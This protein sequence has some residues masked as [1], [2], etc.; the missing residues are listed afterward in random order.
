MK[1]TNNLINYPPDM[2]KQFCKGALTMLTIT[3]SLKHVFNA[4]ENCQGQIRLV[5]GCVRDIVTEGIHHN[6]DLNSA[7]FLSSSDIT[8]SQKLSQTIKDNKKSIIKDIDLATTLKPESVMAALKLYKIKAIPTGLK[9]GTITALHKDGD[10]IRSFEI[11]TLR[12]DLSC[13][14]RHARVEF[15]DVWEEDAARRDFT[16]NALY[17]D[18]EGNIYDYF[19]GIQDLK[20]KKLRFIGDSEQRIQEDYLRILRA[21][22]FHATVCNKITHKTESLDYKPMS[23]EILRVCTKYSNNIANLSGERIHAEMSNI[24]MKDNNLKQ[25]LIFMNQCNILKHIGL[26]KINPATLLMPLYIPEEHKNYILIFAIIIRT[27][28]HSVQEILL[29]I[30]S[31]WKLSNKQFSLLKILVLYN[32]Q[33]TLLKNEWDIEILRLSKQHSLTLNSMKKNCKDMPTAE[34]VYAYVLLIHINEKR[35][36]ENNTINIT[37]KER[38]I[39]SEYVAHIQTEQLTHFPVSGKDIL[40]IGMTP[41]KGIGKIL[42]QIHEE[43]LKSSGNM[44]KN[45]LMKFCKDNLL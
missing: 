37:N 42:D 34:D 26:A 3:N 25:S 17:M 9:H 27:I 36:T 11:T 6:F 20:N 29:Q 13:D 21:F 23:E 32:A 45:E 33:P 12:N 14:G 19:N 35:F 5:G 18:I 4:I 24:M 43:W 7:D 38:D 41:G 10:I 30:R 1:H 2:V 22:R 8:K 44:S 28:N 40:D 15:T 16:F 31:Q 39:Y